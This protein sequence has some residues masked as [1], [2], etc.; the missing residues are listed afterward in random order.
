MITDIGMPEMDG[1]ELVTRLRSDAAAR[2]AAL[3]AIALTAYA[4]IDDRERA[5]KA[6]FQAHLAKPVNFDELLSI[7]KKVARNGH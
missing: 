5:L 1:Y 4:S 7:I 2:N 6:G 3:K